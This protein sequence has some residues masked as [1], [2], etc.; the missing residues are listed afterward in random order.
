METNVPTPIRIGLPIAVEEPLSPRFIPLAVA[1]GMGMTPPI[2]SIMTTEVE[3][4]PSEPTRPPRPVRRHL[5]LLP[6]PE[7]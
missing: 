7:G 2:G 6:N 4:V 1:I 3:V 5:R